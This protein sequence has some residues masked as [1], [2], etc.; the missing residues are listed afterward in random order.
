[1]SGVE[2]DGPAAKGGIEPGDVIVKVNGREIQGSMDLSGYIAD[3]KP[4]SSAKVEVWRKGA[5]RELT[6]TVGELAPQ[7]V[8]AGRP[9]AEDGG[10]LGV[11]VRA[12]TPAEQKQAGVS[13][14]VLVENAGGAAA[15]AGVQPGDIILALNSTPVKDAD[16]L[17]SMIEKSGK[18]V[19]LLVQRDDRRIFIPV[20]LA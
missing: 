1:V 19:A 18:Q 5:T 7:K 10:R 13:G 11:A 12:L 2:K 9:D 14:G 4:G 3:L 20:P 17:R 15:Q 16:Q 8:A 6:V